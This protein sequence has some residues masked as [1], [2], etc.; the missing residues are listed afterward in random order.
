MHC[1]D[2]SSPDTILF[3]HSLSLILTGIMA[4]VDGIH[5]LL[6]MFCRVRHIDANVLE[7]AMI[8]INCIDGYKIGCV[9]NVLNRPWMIML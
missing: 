6:L 5:G 7:I 9:F 3:E 4:N 1:L 8:A 2:T